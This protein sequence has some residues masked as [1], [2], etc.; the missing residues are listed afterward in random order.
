VPYELFDG[1]E[2]G[3]RG[4]FVRLALEY[5]AADYVDVARG[6]GLGRG[7]A[8]VEALVNSY[9]LPTP[10]FAPPFLRDGNIIVSHVANILR[11][12]AP[13]F[14]LAPE[15][16]K[17]DVFAQGL[18]LTIDE[19]LAEWLIAR[20]ADAAGFAA[21]RLP[22]FFGYF[23]RVLARNPFESGWAVGDG[24]SYVDLSLFQ[25]FAGFSQALPDFRASWPR[26]YPRF[27]RLSQAVEARERVAWYLVSDRR[28]EGE[29]AEIFL[30]I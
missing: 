25:V 2:S 28:D 21:T 11:Y 26:A 24:L 6:S 5:A 8:A 20:R 1:P 14:G 22:K 12:L 15:G 18:Q 3:G 9:A 30:P 29:A 16:A 10:P 17:L 23:E 19:L 27:A 7:P 4:E 13:S